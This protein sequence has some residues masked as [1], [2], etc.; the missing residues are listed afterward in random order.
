MNVGSQLQG[1]EDCESVMFSM[2]VIN[3]LRW[4]VCD[5]GDLKLVTLISKQDKEEKNCNLILFKKH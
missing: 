4:I 5:N 2:I 3:G 1:E